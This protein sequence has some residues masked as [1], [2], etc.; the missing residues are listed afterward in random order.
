M[1]LGEVKLDMEVPVILSPDGQ[2]D[3]FDAMCEAV[4][5]DISE[6]NYAMIDGF[7]TES[8]VRGIISDIQFFLESDAFKQAGIGAAHQFQVK[9]EIRKDQILWIDPNHARPDTQFFVQQIRY[10][11]RF[12]NRTCFLGLKDVEMHYAVYESG[13]FYKRHL[14][15]FKVSDHR[16]LTFICY[17]NE[18]WALSDGGCLRMHLKNTDGKEIPFD[19]APLAGRLVCFR[20]DVIEHEV[21]VC[22]RQR[23]S[24]TGW[25]LDQLNELTFL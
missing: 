13:A 23:C 21:L 4:A 11:M 22:H 25:M 7:L 5:T 24:I 19:I 17:L 16:R 1:V 10:L 2:R 8:Q 20:S 9:E 12:I 3:K 6:K 15:Q 14:D 18:G